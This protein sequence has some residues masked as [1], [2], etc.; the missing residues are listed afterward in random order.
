MTGK[1]HPEKLDLARDTLDKL[2]DK[3]GELE[4]GW[5]ERFGFDALAESEARYLI[6]TLDAHRIRDRI[7]TAEKEGDCPAGQETADGVG[8]ASPADGPGTQLDQLPL[9][10][11]ILSLPNSMFTNEK[12]TR[13]RKVIF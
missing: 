10:Q 3:H 5:Q 13:F 2:R 7:A 4:N 11:P 1:P 9:T 6:R 8:S 12:L